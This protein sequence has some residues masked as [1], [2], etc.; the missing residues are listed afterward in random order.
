MKRFLPLLLLWLVFL[1]LFTGC[2][3]TSSTPSEPSQAPREEPPLNFVGTYTLDSRT[4][5]L[6]DQT[7]RFDFSTYWQGEL[8]LTEDRLQRTL[9]P[10]FPELGP[11]FGWSGRYRITGNRLIEMQDGG[12]VITWRLTVTTVEGKVARIILTSNGTDETGTSWSIAEVWVKLPDQ[13]RTGY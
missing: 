5:I 13:P 8:I 4:D 10:L 12:P 11:P 7:R 6:G 3:N 9:T 1:R 2:E